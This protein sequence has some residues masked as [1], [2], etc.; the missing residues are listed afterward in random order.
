[1]DTTGELSLAGK[2]AQRLRLVSSRTRARSQRTTLTGS[3]QIRAVGDIPKGL[4]WVVCAAAAVWLAPLQ[5]P[6]ALSAKER[7]KSSP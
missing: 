2:E 3:G 1:V 5:T 6:C 7:E 4:Q